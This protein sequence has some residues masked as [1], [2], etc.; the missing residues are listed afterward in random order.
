MNIV[1][2]TKMMSSTPNTHDNNQAKRNFVDDFESPDF[3]QIDDLLTDEH[4]LIRDSIRNFVK[5][6]ITPY[7]EDWAERNHFPY[8][9]VKKFGDVGAFGPT[10]SE[11]YGGGGLDYISYGLIMQE[12]ERGDSGMR[13]TAS[14]QG[15][16]VMHPIYAYGSEE[17]KIK[18]LPKLAAGEWLGCFG[19]T[20][21]NH[22][23]NPS[24]METHF[25]DEGDHFLLN[26]AK[27]WISNAPKADIAVVWAK[28]ESGRIKGLIVERGMEGFTTPETHG[29]WSLRASCTGELVFSDVKVPKENLL[30]GKDGLGAPM[31]C[32][33]KARFGIAWGVI[34][35]AM[36]CYESARKYSLERIQ[37]GKPIGSFQLIQKKLA[38]MLS[39]ITKAQ[40]LNWRLGKLMDEGK[41]TTAQISL[42]KRNNVAVALEIAREARQ[43]HG[44]MG[45]TGEYPMMRH[46]MNLESV[47]TYE[48]THDIHLLILGQEITGI[49][50]FN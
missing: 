19:L 27:M 25:T 42:A 36:D 43:I 50:A 28:D 6:E 17:Q 39:E 21:P 48:G 38:E 44:G 14:V 23:S 16:L 2:N 20:E 45:I 5:K 47:L 11:K 4:K 24:G 31:G 1:Y 18:Y 49:S 29:K 7:I 40:L 12:I 41:A 3:Y 10:V 34:G 13:S 32:L 33:D 15:S 9:I 35:A 30:P 46:M 37:F 8:E 26:G 22:G